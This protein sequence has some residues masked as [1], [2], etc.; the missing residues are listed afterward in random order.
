VA[1]PSDPCDRGPKQPGPDAARQLSRSRP[2]RSGSFRS[3]GHRGNLPP[4]IGLL[5]Q[6]GCSPRPSNPQ[7]G[8]KQPGP[9]PARQLQPV[10]PVHASQ[11]TP[12]APAASPGPVPPSSRRAWILQPDPA[13][14]PSSRFAVAMPGEPTLWRGDYPLSDPAAA[15][16]ADKTGGRC[17]Y[18]ATDPGADDP[19]SK[20]KATAGNATGLP[21]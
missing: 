21:A 6:R 9:N 13:S 14:A 7:N 16:D 2:I 3:K 11:L 12:L 20:L 10:P 15:A 4:R 1:P 18:P 8:P 19:A 17:T 5:R